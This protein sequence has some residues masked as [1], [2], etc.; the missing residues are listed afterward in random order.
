MNPTI[1]VTNTN[2]ETINKKI[3][4]PVNITLC[5]IVLE[6]LLMLFYKVLA[7]LY[8]I[9]QIFSILL[10]VLLTIFT[11]IVTYKYFVK[12]SKSRLPA[13]TV[14]L[15]ALYL[16]VNF[17]LQMSF[18]ASKSGVSGVPDILATQFGFLFFGSDDV[19]FFLN[20][21]L[22]WV[23]PVFLCWTMLRN[24]NFLS[25][26]IGSIPISI[27]FALIFFI[28]RYI[29]LSNNSDYLWFLANSN[30]EFY[31][32]VQMIILPALVFTVIIHIIFKTKEVR[33][34]RQF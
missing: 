20:L 27:L 17:G 29:R 7:N 28:E 6:I 33:K 14:S 8:P 22:S 34:N 4:S 19:V 21:I 9:G 5:L 1:I 24:K 13:I 12:K 31:Q 15:L 18:Y 3:L 11:L 2:S 23:L 16:I 10:G 26:I 25:V 30:V 32:P